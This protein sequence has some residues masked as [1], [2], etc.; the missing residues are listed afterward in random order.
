MTKLSSWADKIVLATKKMLLAMKL[1]LKQRRNDG[2]DFFFIQTSKVI[3]KFRQ[4]NPNAV[5]QMLALFMNYYYYYII[6]N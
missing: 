2:F 4:S 5:V 6:H 3:L 1:N